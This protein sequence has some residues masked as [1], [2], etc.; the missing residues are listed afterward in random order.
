MSAYQYVLPTPLSLSCCA[1]LPL[2]NTK[3]SV[4]MQCHGPER[5]AAT[6]CAGG[7]RRRRAGPL[8]TAARVHDHTQKGVCA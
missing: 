5:L 3:D 8:P 6:A 1:P 4:R 7:G 2:L